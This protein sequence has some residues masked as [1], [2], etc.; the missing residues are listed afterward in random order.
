[1]YPC[2]DSIPPEV[3][4]RAFALFM[5]KG[6][7]TY[8]DTRPRAVVALDDVAHK[9]YCP[10]GAI[11]YILCVDNPALLK[12]AKA[13]L[14]VLHMP[15]C[16]AEE[17]DILRIVGLDTKGCAAENFIEDNDSEK[18]SSYEELAAAMG[19]TLVHSAGSIDV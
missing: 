5:Q 13:R 10:W 11:N 7:A 4:Q 19:V 8:H 3:R 15:S 6:M 14:L 16:G 2:F 1:M 12:E 18:F 17:S 9:R